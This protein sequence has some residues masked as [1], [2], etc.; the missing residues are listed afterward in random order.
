MS[1]LA[2]RRPRLPIRA[3]GQALVEFSLAIIVFLI[4]VMGIFDLG[5]GIYL[6]NGVAEASREI[7]RRTAV[8]P[9]VT[10]G[11]SQQTQDVVAIQQGLVP[12]M[13]NPTYACLTITG[14]TSTNDPCTSD[15][16]VQVTVSVTY[17]PISMLGFLGDIP[18]TASSRVQIP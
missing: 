17:R 1:G 5:R 6:Y 10:L 13:G 15:D 8:Y 11:A 18:V 4:L 14:A 7:A 2:R 3:T 16:V 9:G 12:G